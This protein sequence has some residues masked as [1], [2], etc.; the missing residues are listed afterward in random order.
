MTIAEEVT[1]V[2]PTDPLLVAVVS[3]VL[4]LLVGLVVGLVA[5]RGEHNKWLRD[6]RLTAY[7]EY[8]SVMRLAMIELAADPN[9]E[10]TE[11]VI[12]ASTLMALL[13]PTSVGEAAG[14]LSDYLI[15]NLV[16]AHG[17]TKK[18]RLEHLAKLSELEDEMTTRMVKAVGLKH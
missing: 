10:I 11:S 7:S 5:R 4:T 2:A 13:G 3:V 9:L 12:K 14:R 1:T 17:L 6:K 18:A 16:D 15:D 8:L